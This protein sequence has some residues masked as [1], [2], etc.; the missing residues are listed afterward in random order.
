MTNEKIG[1]IRRAAALALI[2]ALALAAPALASSDG[3]TKWR[4][5]LIGNSSYRQLDDLDSCAYDLRQMRLALTSGSIGY[6]KISSQSNL[7][8]EGLQS[9]VNSVL[10][11]G[12]D[13]DDVTV[14]YYTGHGASSGLAGVDYNA[15]SG[16]GIYSFSL[17]QSALANVPGKVIILL[18]ACESGGLIGKS[19]AGSDDFVDNAIRAFSGASSKVTG[20]AITSGDHFHV[21]A[22]SSQTQSSYA[23]NGGYGVATWALC[24]AMG[25]ADNGSKPGNKLISLEGDGDGDLTV[26]VGEAYSYASQEVSSL[27]AKY[28]Y[29]QNMKA[30]PEGSTQ[31]LIARAPAAATPSESAKYTNVAG[32]LNFSKACIAPGKTLQLQLNVK[33]AAKVSWKT[34]KSSVATVDSNGLVTGVSS[35]SVVPR[36]TVF[37]Y[38]GADSFFTY[39]DVRVLPAKYVVQSIRLKCASLT[40]QQN[41]GYTMPVRF[42]P[43][44]A[45]YKGLTWSSSNPDVVAV[46]SSGRILA[47]ASS[48]TATIT[49]T[50]TSGVTDSVVVTAAAAQPTSVS[51]NYRTRTLIPGGTC[52]LTQTVLPAIAKDKSVK[53]KSSKES[54]A[55]VSDTGLVTAVA[56][57]RTTISATTVNNKTATCVVTVVKNESVPRTRPLS[58]Y[59]Q[60]RSSA[61]RIYYN[62]TGSLVVDMYFYNRTGYAQRI[63]TP[64]PGLVVL[65]LKSGAKIPVKVTSATTRPLRN[66]A[67]T[68]YT[69]KLNLEDYPQLMHLNLLGSDASYEAVN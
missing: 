17:L 7:T 65:K 47:K 59:G 46:S 41:Q 42:S 10:T 3:T 50:A 28:G 32:V 2:L 23:L 43:A 36:I 44:S 24:E 63:P 55:T 39:C 18:D 11:W 58:A 15:Y 22:S 51:L 14:V 29:T 4:A 40:L 1:F 60:L 33:N 21:I 61:R 25:W 56:A 66:R 38:V 45:R 16:G 13:E 30:Y 12:A 8:K 68:I 52:M 19:A 64:N 9:A 48:G 54:V 27:L 26:T 6:T 5:L 20:K 53:W 67:Y 37:Y 62:T 35:S 34:S 31:T 57:G 69:F 49:A